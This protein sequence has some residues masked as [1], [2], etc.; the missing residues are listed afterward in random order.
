RMDGSFDD[1]SIPG[2]STQATPPATP[3]N[4]KLRRIFGVQYPDAD[5]V[6]RAGDACGVTQMEEGVP[7]LIADS[8]RNHMRDVVREAARFAVHGRRARLIP[9]DLDDALRL[10]GVQQPLYGM[11]SSHGEPFRFAGSAGKELV[12]RDEG[13]VELTPIINAPPPRM[14]LEPQLKPHWL[15]IDGVQPAVPENPLPPAPAD[16]ILSG[17]LYHYL[18]QSI[19]REE[20]DRADREGTARTLTTHS[21]SLEQQVFFKEI[22]ESV[23]GHD[24]EKRS[25][26]LHCLQTDRGL[27][28]MAPR[29]V[30]TIVEGVR[31]NIGC[32]NLHSLQQLLLMT[33]A[34]MNNRSITMGRVVHDLLPAIVSCCVARRIS[35]RPAADNHWAAREAAAK[36][37]AKMCNS[38]DAGLLRTRVA[39]L[40]MR[41]FAGRGRTARPGMA[42]I[43]GATFALSE[44][45]LET[46]RTLIVPRAAALFADIQTELSREEEEERPPEKKGEMEDESSQEETSNKEGQ[47]DEKKGAGKLMELI[48]SILI[49]YVR[50]SRPPSLRDLSDYTEQLGGFADSVYRNQS[51]IRFRV[52]VTDMPSRPTGSSSS[53]AASH[54]PRPLPH[55]AR[56]TMQPMHRMP[57]S[58]TP[59]GRPAPV[60]AGA[61]GYGGA[62]VPPG[63]RPM[64][65][66]QR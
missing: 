6:R 28:S 35:A 36:L 22:V 16:L 62:A 66:Q 46:V 48:T 11:R 31:T 29:F 21:L 4:L 12:I 58:A 20:R 34:L 7:Q 9:Q 17:R 63:Y 56:S 43:Y 59:R 55:A 49:K 24:T 18:N 39:H 19:Y 42:T 5:F 38:T 27:Q 53:S 57:V 13:E 61:Y 23:V 26:A 50:A 51:P 60:G 64:S 32:R 3:P 41:A 1:S 65:Q 52:T 47:N 10:M 15:V 14:P 44:L 54:L 30:L 25:E 33:H 37:V 40:L 45:G 2:T 8:I